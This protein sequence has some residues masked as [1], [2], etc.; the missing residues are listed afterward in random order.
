MDLFCYLTSDLR[1]VNRFII[2]ANHQI[3]IRKYNQSLTHEMAANR[4]GVFSH[5]WYCIMRSYI[6]SGIVVLAVRQ[7][8]IIADYKPP[9]VILRHLLF[10]VV[11]Q[12]NSI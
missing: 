6:C 4:P 9:S 8:R 7:Y 2:T 3:S 1:T 11:F 10:S 5:F 12:V